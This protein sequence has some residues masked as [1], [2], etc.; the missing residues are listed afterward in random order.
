[1]IIG[2]GLIGRAFNKL[3]HEFNDVCVYASGVSNSNSSDL[4]EFKRDHEQLLYFLSK[5]SKLRRFYYISTCSMY[6][7]ERHN[8]PY[9]KHK[10]NLVKWKI[11]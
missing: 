10:L 4:F 8:S 7:F 9:V 2:S 3:K 1:M 11:S 5:Y 6:D